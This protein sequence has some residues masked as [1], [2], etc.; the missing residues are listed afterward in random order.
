MPRPSQHI[1][2]KLLA[3]GRA[4]VAEKGFAALTVRAAALRAGV[5]PGMFHYHFKT[6]RVFKRRVLEA[7]YEDF[8]Q[9]FTLA[10]Q[11]RGPLERLRESLRYLG[12]FAGTHRRVGFTLVQDA[13]AG[14]QDTVNFIAKNFLRHIEIIRGLAVE[15]QRAGE[16][17]PAP[18][19][20]VMTFL[21]CTVGL[22]SFL[23]E[24]LR[25]SGARR[26]YGF[27]YSVVEK[28]LFTETAIDR[29]V[30]AALR[31]LGAA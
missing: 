30:D 25:R 1:D 4:L 26:P 31:G 28:A 22:P 10:I 16:L 19:P 17:A 8:F 7:F 18:L 3:A 6:K 24:A 29:R 12:R 13:L 21:M 14:N 20:F 9:R 15:A 11:G 27:P 2:Q 23:L 5:N